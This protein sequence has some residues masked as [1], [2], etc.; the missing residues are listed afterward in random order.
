MIDSFASYEWAK[1]PDS[2]ITLD[3]PDTLRETLEENRYDWVYE[4]TMHEI[5]Y[6]DG[7]FKQTRS[8]PNWQGGIATMTTCKQQMRSWRSPE[9]WIGLWNVCYCPSH[10]SHNAMFFAGRVVRTFE[11]NYDYG[12][13]LKDESP[14]IYN[15]KLA[16]M[17]PRGD[18][19][20]PKRKLV[21]EERYDPDNFNEP[22]NHTR[23]I[24]TYKDG[25]PKW[26]KDIRYKLHGRR[27]TV[28]VYEP[29][30]LFSR[31]MVWPV[32]PPGRA[33]RNTQNH[34]LRLKFS[35]P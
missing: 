14:D 31:P 19:Y 10:C 21:G 30:F 18:L 32:N 22:R 6:E 11:S 34:G 3:D 20:T 25:T 13:A 29:A 15:Y 2:T 16:D 26:W 23:S 28:L 1:H 27:P 5:F 4:F 7:I 12:V 24:E 33:V 9:D 17:D 8:S 35:A